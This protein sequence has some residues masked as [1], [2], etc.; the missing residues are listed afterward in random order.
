MKTLKRIAISLYI[1]LLITGVI[2]G[3]LVG[4]IIVLL[5]MG[6]ATPMANEK[7]V[8]AMNYISLQTNKL[9]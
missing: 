8:G 2:I 9:K 5:T 6:F 3:V 1:T 4:S 7:L